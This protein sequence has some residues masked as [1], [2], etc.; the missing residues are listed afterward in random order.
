MADSLAKQHTFSLS[1]N[2]QYTNI[3]NPYHI[4]QW[5]QNPVELPTRHFIKN[6]CKAYILAMWSSQKRNNEWAHINHYIDW[7][8]TWFYLNHNQKPHLTLLALNLIN[9]KLS[10][11]K[12]Y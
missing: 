7:Q 10:K 11:S 12:F 4:L 9:L 6:I 3:Y 2:F 8:S 5:E 1:L